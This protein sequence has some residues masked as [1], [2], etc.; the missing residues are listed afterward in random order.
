MGFAET[1]VA[2]VVA[3]LAVLYLWKSKS[4]IWRSLKR[5]YL[6]FLCE[7]LGCHRW[8]DKTYRSGEVDLAND[9][10]PNRVCLRCGLKKY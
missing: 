7:C 8:H 1:V 4:K 6:R 3:G 5:R 10:V 2:S 9:D